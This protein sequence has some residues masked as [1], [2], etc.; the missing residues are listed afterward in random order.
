MVLLGRSRYARQDRGMMEAEAVGKAY[1]RFRRD[2]VSIVEITRKFP[3]CLTA[4]AWFSGLCW[5]GRIRCLRRNSTGVQIASGRNAMPCRCREKEC[6]K[7]FDPKNGA[8]MKGSKLGFQS[9]VVAAF[10]SSSSPKLVSSIR[11]SRHLRSNQ[12]SAMALARQ[13]HGPLAK[14][15]AAPVGPAGMGLTWVGV[16]RIGVSNSRKTALAGA[17]TGTGSGSVVVGAK[18]RGTCEIAAKRLRF[19]DLAIHNGCNFGAGS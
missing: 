11:R 3:D 4:E 9:W 7:G 15:R 19:R 6:A 8:A 12:R 5:P 14:K 16:R 10:P 13:L 1:G 18:H 2:G 17:A